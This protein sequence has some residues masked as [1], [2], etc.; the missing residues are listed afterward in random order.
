[1]N[2]LKKLRC[3][4][5]LHSWFYFIPN[6]TRACRNCLK[7]QQLTSY[8]QEDMFG[9][10]IKR[11]H[12]WSNYSRPIENPVPIPPPLDPIQQKAKES[13]ELAMIN[14]LAMIK[15]APQLDLECLECHIAKDA[16]FSF[17]YAQN[18]L[19]SRFIAGETSIAKAQNTTY[20]RIYAIYYLKGRFIEA[21]ET[22][23]KD[24]YNALIYAIDV[25]NSRFLI[26]EENILNSPHKQEYLD[27]FINPEL[28]KQQTI[29]QEALITKQSHFNNP[30]TTIQL[31]D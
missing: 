25:L 23:A 13:Y 28:N 14:E 19:K 2:I 8:T 1:M 11:H 22:I 30:I 9:D 29:Y 24:P 4:L 15:N 26:A 16:E 17:K 10:I 5:G 20:P 21:E 12:K 6:N 7:Y 18:V 31:E 27:L 3:K